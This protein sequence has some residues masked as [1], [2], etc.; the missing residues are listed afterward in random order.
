M[1][2]KKIREFPAIETGPLHCGRMGKRFRVKGFTIVELMV[3]MT[4]L[5]IAF[6]LITFLYTRAAKIRKVVVLTSEIQQVL[7]QMM[8]TLTYGEKGYWGL[9]D[10]TQVNPAS[11]DSILNINSGTNVMQARIDHDAEGT[12]KI[13]W[14]DFY[15][16]QIS[17]DPGQKVTVNSSATAEP[18]IPLSKFEYFDSS[19]TPITSNYSDTSFVKITLWAVSTDPTLKDAPPISLVTGVKLHNKTSF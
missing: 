4:I 5:I 9:I 14:G 2:R 10:A 11:S 7:S 15:T 12:I 13:S 1:K 17:L 18:V 6:G 19:G 8:D 16:D 3:A